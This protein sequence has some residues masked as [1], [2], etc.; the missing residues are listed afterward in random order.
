LSSY[1][2]APVIFCAL[3]AHQTDSKVMYKNHMNCTEGHT[4]YSSCK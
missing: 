2:K 1:D 4:I 3:T